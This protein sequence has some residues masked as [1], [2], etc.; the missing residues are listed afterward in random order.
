MT[1]PSKYLTEIKVIIKCKYAIS[2]FGCSSEIQ[3]WTTAAE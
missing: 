3:M 1:K 2:Q